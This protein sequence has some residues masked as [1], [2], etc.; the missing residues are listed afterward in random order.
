MRQKIEPKLYSSKIKPRFVGSKENFGDNDIGVEFWFDLSSVRTK[1]C[2]SVLHNFTATM[3][4]RRKCRKNSENSP[5]ATPKFRA[6]PNL[7]KRPCGELQ[8]LRQL[9]RARRSRIVSCKS[10]KFSENSLPFFCFFSRKKIQKSFTK[11]HCFG[12]RGIFISR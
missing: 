1:R 12:V 3:I 7:K 9:L 4:G 11:F 10:R 6:D 2:R 5:S 8:P